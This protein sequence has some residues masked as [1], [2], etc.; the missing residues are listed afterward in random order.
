MCTAC[1]HCFH[2]SSHE[3]LPK[4]SVPV[5]AENTAPGKSGIRVDHIISLPDGHRT[6]IAKLLSLPNLTGLGFENWKHELVNWMQKE[7]GNNTIKTTITVATATTTPPR[8]H[9]CC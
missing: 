8:H 9:R 6:A 4:I 1:E 3:L 5:L 7:E 2:G